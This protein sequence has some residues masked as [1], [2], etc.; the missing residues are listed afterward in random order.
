MLLESKM[1][2]PE[3]SKVVCDIFLLLSMSRS[4]FVFN[5][6]IFCHFH[7]NICPQ[8]FSFWS[9]E[10]HLI[11]CEIDSISSKILQSYTIAVSSS[12]SCVKKYNWLV[13][14]N[15]FDRMQESKKM[16]CWV[17]K[18]SYNLFSFN[19]FLSFLSYHILFH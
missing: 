8:Y 12:S 16:I 10:K 14:I 13:D 9:H 11:M 6:S 4:F 7:A 19:F 15:F 17:H 1:R 3:T 5:I 2:K 18:I